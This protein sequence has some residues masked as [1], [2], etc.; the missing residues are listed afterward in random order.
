MVVEKVPEPV[1]QPKQEPKELPKV[2]N[3]E[4]QW[5]SF[6][7]LLNTL[8]VQSWLKWWNICIR[9]ANLIKPALWVFFPF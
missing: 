2:E 4:V 9:V 3:E 6:A 8:V 5:P 1:Q 7:L